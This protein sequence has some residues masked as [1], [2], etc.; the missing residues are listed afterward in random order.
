META[1]HLP[2][3][4]MRRVIALA[5]DQPTYRILIV[6]DLPTNRQLLIRLLAP[7]G[8]DLREASNGQEA[9]AVWQDV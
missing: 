8:F 1:D 4:T 9:L 6:D 7:L 3:N 5:P 2:S